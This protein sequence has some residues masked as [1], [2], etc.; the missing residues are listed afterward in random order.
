MSYKKY[1]VKKKLKYKLRLLWTVESVVN[2]SLNALTWIK[3]DPGSTSFGPSTLLIK[4]VYVKY[5]TRY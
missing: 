2:I 1:Q 3:V 5:M 4:S